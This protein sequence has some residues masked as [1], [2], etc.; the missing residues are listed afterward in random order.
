MG[1]ID[2]FVSEGVEILN[3]ISEPSEDC[4]GNHLMKFIR[5]SHRSRFAGWLHD[6]IF[7]ANLH[8]KVDAPSRAAGLQPIHDLQF[9]IC[10][11]VVNIGKVMLQVHFEDDELCLELA[12]EHISY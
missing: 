5:G 4:R 7:K 6:A 1:G 3:V 8:D 9:K 2:Q 10:D 12:L 11:S